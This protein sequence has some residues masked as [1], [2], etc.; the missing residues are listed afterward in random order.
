V[1]VVE[2]DT[3]IGEVCYE[4][5]TYRICKLFS[6]NPTLACLDH[7]RRAV[8]I[9]GAHVGALV[10]TQLLESNPDIGLQILHK[11][12]HVDRPIRVRQAT[13]YKNFALIV[14]H[15]VAIV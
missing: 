3:E 6:L 7:Y 10:A 2:F 8:G 11:M 5:L 12:T 1:V 13:G 14:R 9:A 4:F 15:V